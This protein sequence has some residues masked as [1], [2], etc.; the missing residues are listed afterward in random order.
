MKQSLLASLLISTALF[1]ATPALAVP[2]PKEKPVLL[3]A[4]F[5]TYDEK[6]GVV[7]AEGKVH[8]VQ[9][10]QVVEADSMSYDRRT[11]VVIAK[12]NVRMWQPSGDVIS[13]EYAELSR[14]L[15][16]A[17]IRQTS[18]LMSDNSRFIALEGER[19]EGR[20]V[21]MNRALYTACDACKDDPHKPP[22]WQL[23]AQRVVHDNEK[24]D[25]IYRNATL[26][27]AG[28]PVFYT[29]Y[30]A[31]PDPSVKRR[32]G[33]LA[34]VI[35]SR[36]NLGF[37]TRTFYF[38]DV[39][40][41]RDAT[42]ETSYSSTRGVLVGG[43]WRQKTEHS[44][45]RVN[46]SGTFDDIP[47]DDGT[48][49]AEAE[50]LRGHFFLDADHEFN[51]DWRAEASIRRT[52][53]DTYLDLWKYSDEDV[54]QSQ[55]KVEHFTPRSHAQMQ[56]RSYQ[57]L[58]PNITTDEPNVATVSYTAQG[59]PRE[60]MGGRWFLGAETR[61]VARDSSTN[62][63]RGSFSVGW[64]RQDVLPAGVVFTTETT[65][66]ADGFMA[67][68]LNG[69]DPSTFR[70]FAQAQFTASWP[71]V[72]LGESGQ[73]FIEPIAQ[74]TLA[75]RQKRDD[76][77]I[78]NEDSVGLEFDTTN[79]FSS[80]RY[81]GNDRL[82]G[83]QRLAYG[84]RGGW[85][86]NSGNSFTAAFG[87]S[88]DFAENPNYAD[89]TG[90]EDQYSDFVASLDVSLKHADIAYTTRLDHDTFDPHEHDLRASFGPDWLKA[91][92]SYLY[93]DQTSADGSSASLR[94]E[95]G[96]GAQYKFADNW[97]L[98]G[99]HR[100]NLRAGGGPL[101]TDLSLTYQ[102]ECLTYSLMAQRDYLSRSG[103]SSGDSV[104]FRITFKNLGEFES[105]SFSPDLLGGSGS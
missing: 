68:D 80:N 24:H 21:R 60:A 14:D 64:R 16:Q 59:A 25:V 87:Q 1:S 38:L 82:D 70:P 48:T 5:M 55:A 4:N 78:A 12:G 90:L 6:A 49:K 28:V 27:L 97:T 44:N 58:R 67:T 37:V 53:D 103:L 81:S 33:F 102:D 32:S 3:D 18:L 20:Y 76:D 88:Y 54:L 71:M 100:E 83:G 99:W 63:S 98:Y 95:L 92:S 101:N 2:L 57:D 86:G 8:L 94:E 46:A 84:L 9:R 96:F 35:G 17:F 31:H 19:T 75:P 85:T 43:E 51:Q 79:L 47:N 23:R 7:T 61:Q 62:S 15:R 11:G 34:P 66:R 22:L 73:Q 26:E 77:D 65:A 105:P 89:G 104:F 41:N 39:D 72:K 91:T 10:G 36:N 50:Q 40:P 42:I 69:E 93:I 45:I 52:T 74:L 30:L 56:V 29:P 13:A